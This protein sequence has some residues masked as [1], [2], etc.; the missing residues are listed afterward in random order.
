MN[1]KDNFA[2]DVESAMENTVDN[3]AQDRNLQVS[4]AFYSTRFQGI[5]IVCIVLAC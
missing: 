3:A 5:F 2:Y 4:F 1:G